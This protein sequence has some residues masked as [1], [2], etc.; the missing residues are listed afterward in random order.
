MG[1]IRYIS[2]VWMRPEFSR[3][4]CKLDY[5]LHRANILMIVSKPWVRSNDKKPLGWVLGYPVLFPGASSFL[6]NI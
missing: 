5:E 3:S 2:L 6:R 4:L 1:K